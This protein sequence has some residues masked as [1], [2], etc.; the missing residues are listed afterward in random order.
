VYI[1]FDRNDYPGDA[2]LS[3][4][5]KN[6]SYT[7]FWLNAP[8]GDSVNSWLGKRALLRQAGFGFLILFNGLTDAELK[9]PQPGLLGR[10]AGRQAAEL[11]RK[12]G[13]PSTAIVFLDQEE[14]G[15][16]LPEQAA[17][18]FGWIDG[19]RESGARAG[20][21]CSGI[22]VPDG[23]STI[24]TAQDILQRDKSRGDKTPLTLW[25]AQDACPPSPGCAVSSRSPVAGLQA[26]V[27]G[28][29]V[30]QYA[31]SPRRKQFSS[32]C[33][34]RQPDYDATN[35]NCYAPGLAHS[36]NTF[37]DLDAADSADP[38]HGR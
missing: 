30:W 33:P 1:G 3:A 31:Q 23:A 10:L 17:Y 4:L 12:Q 5:R 9:G 20:V 2:Y 35:G 34:A 37:L 13:F 16:L 29:T 28:V 32:G 38:S 6:F 24:T 21:Y 26:Q 22:P 36:A 18:V 8:P 11:A 7:S 14:G 15:R 27:P 19:V 25:I